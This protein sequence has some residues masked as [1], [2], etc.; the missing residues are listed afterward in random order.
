MLLVFDEAG[1][2]G[3]RRGACWRNA[4]VAKPMLQKKASGRRDQTQIW[5]P[6]ELPF[7]ALFAGCFDFSRNAGLKAIDGHGQMKRRHC[8]AMVIKIVQRAGQGGI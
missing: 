3:Q 7:Q 8:F 1:H 4:K 6:F 2:R 5:R